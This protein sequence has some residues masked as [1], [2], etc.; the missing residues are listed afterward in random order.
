[1]T[2]QSDKMQSGVAKTPRGPY[3]TTNSRGRFYPLDPRPEE[4]DL[5]DISHAL[6]NLCRYNGHCDRFYSVAEHSVYVSEVVEYSSGGNPI[7]TMCALMH[8][9][10]EAY[11][12]DMVRPIKSFMP[13]FSTME[14]NIWYYAISIKFGLPKDIS[15]IVHEADNLLCSTEKRDLLAGGEV[16]CNMPKPLDWMDIPAR[17]IPPKEAELMFIKRYFEIKEMM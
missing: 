13:M 9:A 16:W 3:I 2:V 10:T 11:I 15:D 17:E 1:M 8:D 7:E 12:G 4:V 5:E 6:S 14:D